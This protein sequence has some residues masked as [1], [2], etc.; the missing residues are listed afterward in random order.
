MDAGKT[1]YRVKVKTSIGSVYLICVSY[2]LDSRPSHYGLDFFE[3]SWPFGLPAKQIPNIRQA[4]FS[5]ELRTL[6]R[7]S[8]TRQVDGEEEKQ[9]IVKQLLDVYESNAYIALSVIDQTMETY[10]F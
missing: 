8:C 3:Y 5:E 1:A 6:H 10:D 7:A 4:T 2:P 9:F